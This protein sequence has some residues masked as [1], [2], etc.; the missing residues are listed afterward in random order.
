[1]YNAFI[2]RLNAVCRALGIPARPVSNLVSAHDANGTLTID[3][4]YDAKNNEL[5]YDPF[6]PDGGKDS[7]WNFHV[8][9]EAWMA[10][11]DLPKGTEN[12]GRGLCIDYNKL[13]ASGYG[14]WQAIDATPQERSD[15]KSSLLILLSSGTSTA[16]VSLKRINLS[17]A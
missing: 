17:N 1:M 4:Y 5:E 11:P 12:I 3:R 14:G 2:F 7:I 6:N 10:R 13:Y 8:W 9:T 16:K 15:G